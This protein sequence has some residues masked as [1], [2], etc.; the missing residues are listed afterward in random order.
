MK[1]YTE[2][3]ITPEELKKSYLVCKN[4]VI[5]KQHEVLIVGI[6]LYEDENPASNTTV[7]ISKIDSNF[8]SPVITKI[9]FVITDEH[10]KFITYLEKI[11][12]VDYLLEFYPPG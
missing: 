5:P 7:M 12:K 6:V 2:I 11:D 9:G 1:A 8:T 4:I 10:G 3:I